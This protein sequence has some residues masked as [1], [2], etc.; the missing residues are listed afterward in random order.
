MQNALAGAL[1]DA[2]LPLVASLVML[3]LSPY[4]KAAIVTMNGLM[5]RRTT[6]MI[7]E[8]FDAAVDRAISRAEGQDGNRSVNPTMQAVKYLYETMGETIEGLGVTEAQLTERV[9]AQRQEQARYGMPIGGEAIADD[10]ALAAQ[11]AA[12]PEPAEEMP[13]GPSMATGGLT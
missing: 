13:A 12:V 8:R 7:L 1:I 6:N 10:A 5:G 11:Q 4:L 3:F 9:D 2:A